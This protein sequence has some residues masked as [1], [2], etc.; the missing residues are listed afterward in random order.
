MSCT[1]YHTTYKRW[2]LPGGK[3]K[4]KLFLRCA[5]KEQMNEWLYPQILS[6]AAECRVQGAKLLH[7]DA[8]G[9]PSEAEEGT[10]IQ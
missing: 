9:S 1:A 3:R 5:K 8:T 6:M 10:I 2:T 4:S 7:Q